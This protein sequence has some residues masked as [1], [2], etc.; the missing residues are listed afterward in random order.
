MK[1]LKKSLTESLQEELNLLKFISKYSGGNV[2]NKIESKS[3]E[4]IGLDDSNSFTSLRI[5]K[6][7][8][9]YTYSAKGGIDQVQFSNGFLKHF[10]AEKE[11]H[12]G[13]EQLDFIQSQIDF[14]TQIDKVLVKDYN[15]IL[16]SLK[17][18]FEAEKRKLI[19]KDTFT[20]KAKEKLAEQGSKGKR[21]PDLVMINSAREV[22]IKSPIKEPTPQ[23]VFNK[24]KAENFPYKLGWV[25]KHLKEIVS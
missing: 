25:K 18:F 5:G 12:E 7:G 10:H 22:L 15:Q 23:K 21:K 13:L 20:N 16:S 8:K 2:H 9:E 6:D 24:L 1:N 11:R 14:I 19:P 4:I 3:P 17:R